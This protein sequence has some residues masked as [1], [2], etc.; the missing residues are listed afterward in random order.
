MENYKGSALTYIRKHIIPSLP[1]KNNTIDFTKSI[2]VYLESNNIRYIRK[3]KG[4]SNR[5]KI[6]KNGPISFTVTDNEPALWAYMECFEKRINS[7]KYYH[8]NTFFPI[9]FALRS[10]EK[11]EFSSKFNYGKKSRENN[12]SKSRLKHCHI[13]D[14][15][16]RGTNLIDLNINQRML[17]LMSP[18][19]HFPFPAPRH[20]NMIGGDIGESKK[21]L[22]L[23][24]HTLYHEFY[25]NIEEKE[26]FL[27]FLKCSGDNPNFNELTTD[28][29]IEFSLKKSSKKTKTNLNI[30]KRKVNS[31]QEEV[32]K[33]NDY[34]NLTKSLI[35]KKYFKISKNWYGK[36]MM[37]QVSFDKGKY[38]DNI[39]VYNHDKVYDSTINY[40]ETLN[41]WDKSN[42]Y[43]NSS[44]IP[45]WA[46]KY[47]KKTNNRE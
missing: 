29:N 25:K 10:E 24:K 15:S 46:N 38:Q 23:L 39:F 14:C 47:V 16:P 21:F 12:F 34:K 9:A 20:F 37:I 1:N 19:N 43:S 42:F 26:S 40:L 13:L 27:E 31:E 4:Y 5:G 35:K 22:K 41:C 30:T 45:T 3:F 33:F 36:G 11:K 2:K 6:Y 8:D 32:M 7:F 28:F 44:N 17:R 18:M